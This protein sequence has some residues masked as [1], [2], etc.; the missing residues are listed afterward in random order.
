MLFISHFLI[1][2]RRKDDNDI[3]TVPGH[4]LWAF[5]TGTFN[6]LTKLVFCFL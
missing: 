3:F 2:F 4:E 6:Q 1:R 5:R